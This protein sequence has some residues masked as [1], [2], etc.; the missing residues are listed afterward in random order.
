MEELIYLYTHIDLFLLIFVRIV[1]ALSFLPVIEESKIPPLA[2]GGISTCLAY[3]TILTITAPQLE[4]H[5]TLLSFTVIIIKECVI[6]IILGFG[7][8]IFFQVYYFVG[9]LLG[10]QGGLGMSMMFDPANSTQVPILGRFY[11]LA[12][13]AVFILSGGYHWFIKTLVESFQYIPINQVIFRP[14]IV[15]TI[16]DAVSDYWLISFK[17]AIPVL[18]VLL[19]IDCGLGIL[20]RTVPQMNMFV[21]GIPLKMIILF[22]LLIFTIGLIPVFNDMILEHMIN[23]I[24]NTLQ[25]M[26]P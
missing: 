2:I 22:S 4:Y 12:F 10:M 15:G 23:M 21:I 14:N 5:P 13:S 20:A 16:V 8:R 6:G 18:A 3:I 26:I 25:G 11:M 9:T 17:L 19:I 24:M 7:V 1:F